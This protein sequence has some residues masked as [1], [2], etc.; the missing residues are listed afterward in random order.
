MSPPRSPSRP[1]LDR[2]RR[3]VRRGRR[4]GRRLVAGELTPTDRYRLLALAVSLLAGLAVFVLATRLFPYHS[5]ND[6]EAVYLLQAAMLLEGQVELQAG[7]LADA[8]RPWFF[9]QDGGRLYP[10][11]NPVPSGMFAVSMALFGEP[12]VTLAVVAAGNAALVYVLGSAIFDRSVGVVAAAVFAASPLALLTSSVFLPYA[13]TTFLNLLFA[14]AYLRGVRNG[15]LPSA[16][17]AGVAVGLAFFAR[18]YTAVLFATPFVAHALWQ[19]VGTVS[20]EGIG[21]VRRPVPDPI[22]RNAL[23]GALGLSFVALTLAYNARV[24][25]S[26]LVFPYQAF[27]PMDG[28]GFGRRVLLDHSIDYTP[29]LALESNGYVLRY[30]AARWMTAGPLGTLLAVCGLGLAIRQWVPGSPLT[31]DSA[32]DA[33]H[34]RTAGVLLA[35]VLPAVVLGNLAFWGNRNA[36][37]TMTDPTDGLLSQFGPYYY[38]DTLPVLAVFAGVALVAAWRTLRRGRVHAWLT[39]RTSTNGARR[40]AIAVALVSALAIGGA[41]AAVVS[42]PVERHAEHTETFETAYEPFEEADLENAL[43]F[44][45]PEYGEWL[46]HPFQ[47]LRN[48][49][50]LDGEVVYALDGGVERDFAVLDAY[51]ERTY[52]RYAA[53]GEWSPDPDDEYVPTLQEVTLREGTSFDGE[54][55]VG[56]LTTVESAIVRLETSDGETA[57]YRIHEPGDAV[58]VEWRVTDGRAELVTVDD[59]TGSNETVEN[60]SVPLDDVDDLALSVTMHETV[61]SS[62]TYRQEVPVRSTDEGVEVLWPA[63]RTVCTLVTRCEDEGTYVPGESDLYLDGVSFEAELDV[64]E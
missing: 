55:R 59:G 60:G 41:N 63:E 1:L 42:T 25:G 33:D 9:V 24:T 28:P 6:D 36:L 49:P 20:R 54:T 37:A 51:P 44:L 48:D 5:T 8:V 11:Y 21:A 46:G 29:A 39:A 7:P 12:R 30:Y 58:T 22:R 10:K 40:V 18:P 15:H 38:F 50:G 19:V 17:A 61:G 16:A 57:T 4:F 35:G 27:A 45:P 52:Y 32:D 26:P 3:S 34:R 47:A 62:L 23:T 64:R 31:T 53:H 13:P 2:G 14:V 43:V 56:T